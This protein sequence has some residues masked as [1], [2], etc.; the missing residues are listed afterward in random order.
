MV[1]SLST[2]GTS[3]TTTAGTR[4]AATVTLLLEVSESVYDVNSATENSAERRPCYSGGQS[5][6]QSGEAVQEEASTFAGG[7][8]ETSVPRGRGSSSGSSF[9]TPAIVS[10]FRGLRVARGVLSEVE[11]RTGRGEG[12]ESERPPAP[13]NLQICPQA[14]EVSKERV[15]EVTA[16]REEEHRERPDLTSV[17]QLLGGAGKDENRVLDEVGG[18]LYYERVCLREFEFDV[19]SRTF[20]YPCPCGD[21]FEVSL[22]TIQGKVQETTGRQSGDLRRPTQFEKK[23]EAESTGR[24][25]EKAESSEETGR[26]GDRELEVEASC[27][28]CSLKVQAF[29]TFN[30]LQELLEE[31]G[32]T[33]ECMENRV[34]G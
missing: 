2:R 12:P 7:S 17:D 26:L 34:L 5:V 32:E 14:Q 6:E 8:G 11:D 15:E 4:T 3:S 16:E 20:F 13:G 29:F 10:Q 28:S 33:L 25:H 18:E 1:S 30:I 22:E 23:C 31:A 19:S 21:L 9:F 24:T 27:P